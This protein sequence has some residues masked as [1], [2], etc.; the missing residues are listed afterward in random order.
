MKCEIKQA[1]EYQKGFKNNLIFTG[2]E[3]GE[4]QW[5]GTK[6]DFMRAEELSNCC[7]AKI[8]Q[9]NGEE[10]FC[11]DCGEHCSVELYNPFL[12]EEHNELLNEKLQNEYMEEMMEDYDENSGD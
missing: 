9:S 6:E 3:K 5:L 4:I 1:K 10:G 2:F 11:S 8:N 12:D 7:G